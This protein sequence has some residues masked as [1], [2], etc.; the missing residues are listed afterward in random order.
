MT[1]DQTTEA[2]EEIKP[3]IRRLARFGYMA[4][5]VVYILIGVLA[6]M[7]ALG[8]GGKTTGTTGMLRSLAGIPFG[9]MLLWIIGIGLVFYICWVLIKA[10]KDPKNEGTDTKGLIA[11]TGYFISGLI[12][13]ALAWNAFKIAGNA[14]SSSGGSQQTMSAKLLSQPFGQW[15]IG[16]VGLIII[17]YGLYELHGGITKKFLNKFR[18]GEMDRHE[19]KIASKSGTIGLAARGVVLGLIGYF[20]IQ[21]AMTANPD[22][23]KGLDGALSEVAQKPFGQW[24]LGLTALGL[25]LYGIYQIT[26]G[27]FEH[28]SFGKRK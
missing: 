3:W 9:N 4:K 19:K 2:K 15:I 7:A 20:F 17:G 1:M 21:T 26:R 27:R 14:G 13:G 22:K 6:L 11:R 8:I 12:Y 24:L 18:V 23:A 10:I 25:V 16:A 28:M 5:G